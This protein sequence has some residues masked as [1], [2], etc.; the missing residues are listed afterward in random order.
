MVV[1]GDGPFSA[2]TH[3]PRENG[4]LAKVKSL[5]G[6]TLSLGPWQL[7]TLLA[8]C[9]VQRVSS[10]GPHG[11]RHGAYH[12]QTEHLHVLLGIVVGKRQDSDGT[13]VVAGPLAVEDSS[14]FLRSPAGQ[15]LW[16]P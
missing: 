2:P 11:R 9:E 8:F 16:A 4:W 7:K 13:H 5:M 15:Q 3:P 10:C 6:R 12:D 14:G 1:D